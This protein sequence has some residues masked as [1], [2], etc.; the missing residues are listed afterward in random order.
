MVRLTAVVGLVLL[1]LVLE[2]CRP[3]ADAGF[4]EVALVQIGG[5]HQEPYLEWAERKLLP[6]LRYEL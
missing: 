6:A 1:L 5:D 4:T 2:A 3:Y